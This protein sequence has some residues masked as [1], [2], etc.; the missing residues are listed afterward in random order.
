MINYGIMASVIFG[1]VTLKC[2]I[3]TD[4]EGHMILQIH[5]A[6]VKCVTL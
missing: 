4:M 6:C 3:K 1:E 5:D 2:E